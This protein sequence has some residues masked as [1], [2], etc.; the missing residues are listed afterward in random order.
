M[1]HALLLELQRYKET[2]RCAALGAEVPG[3]HQEQ[4]TQTLIVRLLKNALFV[5]RSLIE[6]S[7]QNRNELVARPGNDN[8]LELLGELLDRRAVENPE[9]EG[10][11]KM[12][13]Q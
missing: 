3:Q 6:K 11:K 12:A 4:L 13:G 7:Q 1:P 2:V 9:W 8:F 5:H 10:G